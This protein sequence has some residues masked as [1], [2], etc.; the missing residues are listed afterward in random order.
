[1]VNYVFGASFSKENIYHA[2]VT[3]FITKLRI[4]LHGI[5]LSGIRVMAA[6]TSNVNKR[7]AVT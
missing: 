2:H 3:S 5:M 6:L 1:M 7:A 4:S